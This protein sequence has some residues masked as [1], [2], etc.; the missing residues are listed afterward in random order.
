[1]SKAEKIAILIT[2]AKEVST[3]LP[4]GPDLQRRAI[5]L[6]C[7][8]YRNRFGKIPSQG[9]IDAAIAQGL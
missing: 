1:M 5:H 8:V 9:I 4:G 7:S 3:H 6:A 2:I